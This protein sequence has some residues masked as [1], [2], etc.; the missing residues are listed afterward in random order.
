MTL[1]QHYLKQ[2][3]EIDL[4]NNMGNAA[5]GAHAVAIGGLWQAIVI[6]FAGLQISPHGLTFSPM[7]LQ[8]W[9]RLAF[10]LEWHKRKLRVCVEPNPMRVTLQRSEPLDLRLAAGPR[11]LAE[12]GCECVAERAQGDGWKPW[13]PSFVS[14]LQLERRCL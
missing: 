9:R 11:I 6:G 8:H 4:A 13:R 10:P 7:L 2:A 14:D 5:G 1:A 12:P 3:T